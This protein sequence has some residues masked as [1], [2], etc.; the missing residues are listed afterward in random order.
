MKARAI[1]SALIAILIAGCQ[2]TPL[3][4][5]ADQVKITRSNADVIGCKAVG[6]IGEVYGPTWDESQRQM[7]NQAI[8]FGGNL[9]L[10]TT[11]TS[12]SGVVYRCP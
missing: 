12:I 11:M 6:N 1:A 10:N 4:P 2:E 9:V 3:V 7:K 8:G 5:G